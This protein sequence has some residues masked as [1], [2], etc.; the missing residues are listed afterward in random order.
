MSSEV[1]VVKEGLSP[2]YFNKDREEVYSQ[3]DEQFGAG[4]WRVAWRLADGEIQDYN[5]QFLLNFVTGYA[6]HF[7]QHPE[8]ARFLTEGFS[9]AYDDTLIPKVSAFDPEAYYNRPGFRNQIHHAALNIALESVL[10]MPFKGDVPIQVRGGRPGTNQAI[11]PLGWRWHPGRIMTPRPD[12]I[13]DVQVAKRWH[14]KEGSI[15]H[16]YQA[17]K[18]IQVKEIA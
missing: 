10:V 15:E 16:M 17:A 6:L 3:F 5:R 1:W 8:E 13:P 14:W 18:V 2:G 7:T 9:Y 11:W 4:C 12:L